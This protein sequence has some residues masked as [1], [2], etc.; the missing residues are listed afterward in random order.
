MTEVLRATVITITRLIGLAITIAF[1]S[2][3]TSDR[4]SLRQV[5]ANAVQEVLSKRLL[6]GDGVCEGLI[7]P[8]KLHPPDWNI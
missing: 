7:E 3:S 5:P 8:A 6:F 4:L 1:D 2:A